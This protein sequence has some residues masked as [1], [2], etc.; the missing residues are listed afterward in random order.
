MLLVPDILFAG[1]YKSV[2]N[3]CWPQAR[4]P[5]LWNVLCLGHT[6]SHQ[7]SYCGKE[8]ASSSVPWPELFLPKEGICFED[9]VS[10]LDPAHPTHPLLWTL[11]LIEED[12][13]LLLTVAV[14]SLQV[15][16]P[17]RK[18]RNRVYKK[19]YLVE[20]CHP[21][22]SLKDTISG[23]IPVC[24]VFGTHHLSEIASLC[25]M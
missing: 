19:L 4:S 1:G 6:P 12:P 21:I 3:G 24:V 7:G 23:L 5:A 9:W 17:E 16:R 2:F 15:I 13:F 25:F 8:E 10:H 11:W 18:L 20:K 14:S 22:L